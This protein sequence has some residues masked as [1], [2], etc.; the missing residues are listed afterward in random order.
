MSEQPT[1]SAL[2]A[3]LKLPEPELKALSFCKSATASSVAAWI[4]AQPLTQTR[5]ISAVLYAALP[6][7]AR[8]KT[9]A[10][11]HIDILEQLRPAVQATIQGL[12]KAFLQQPLILPE[13]A[14]KAAIIAQALQKHL[15][16]AYLSA[17]RNALT[18]RAPAELRALA[19]QRALTGLGLL[20]LRSY[21]LYTPPLKGLWLE[22]HTLYRL[23][24]R[25]QLTHLI[26][27][28]PLAADPNTSCVSLAYLRTVL[29]ASA[30]PNQLG[31]SDLHNLYASLEVLAPQ[32]QLQP[33]EPAGNDSLYALMLDSDLPP[34][35]YDRLHQHRSQAVRALDT[36]G[37]CQALQNLKPGSEPRL[38]AALTGHLIAAWQRSAE[39]S[40]PRHAGSGELEVTVGLSNLHFYSAGETPFNLFVQSPSELG[41]DDSGAGIFKQ[42]GLKL[43][44]RINPSAAD[45]WGEAFDVARPTLQSSGHSTRNME[46][47]IRRASREQYRGQHP[48]DRVSIID[49]SAGGYCIEWRG[50]TPANL[51]AGELLGVRELG[52]NKW[53]IAAVRWVQQSRSATQI[54]LQLLAAQAQPAAAAIIQKT[55]E[56]AEYLRV[57]ALPAQRLA[58]RPASLLTNAVSFREMQKIKLYQGGTLTTLQLTRRLFSTGTVSQFAYKTLATAAPEPSNPLG[59]HTDFAALWDK[60]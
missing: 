57:L 10:Q 23:A 8:L 5:H 36:Y 22:V 25:H 46:D 19:I 54:G 16:N 32:A 51:K 37:L 29:M 48:I 49:A 21:Q 45:P 42:R 52:R 50:A 38:S 20:L 59:S 53:G 1:D 14:R 24:E 12:S 55:G 30:R 26:V 11:T 34:I 35:Y 4:D 28:E 9:D 56:Y 60:P 6:E 2:L 3:Q 41:L 58:N 7:L 27:H 47:D 17:A 44:D 33:H 40:Y 13:P 39:R 18:H 31:Q 15:S 43:K